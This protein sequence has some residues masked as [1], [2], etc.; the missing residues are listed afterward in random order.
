MVRYSQQRATVLPFCFFTL[1]FPILKANAACTQFTT[2]GS[3]S[4]YYDFY[5]FYDFRNLA[6]SSE[7]PSIPTAFNNG[8]KHLSVVSW[9]SDWHAVSWFRPSSKP[10]NYDMQYISSAMSIVQNTAEPH[11]VPT[12]LSLSAKRLANGTQFAAELDY[13]KHSVTYASMR[14]MARVRGASGAVA[15]F[16]TYYDDTTE[17]DVEIRTRDPSTQVQLSNQPTTDLSTT[18]PIPGATFTRPVEDYRA[19]NMYRLDWIHGRSAWYINGVQSASTEVNVPDTPSTIILNMWS[20]GGEFSGKMQPEDEASFEVQWIEL[21]Y[22]TTTIASAEQGGEIC[23]VEF[24]PGSP[25]S[26]AS[27]NV[28]RSARNEAPEKNCSWSMGA[29]LVLALLSVFLLT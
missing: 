13:T 8:Q 15:G 5:R 7:S 22:N 18:V 1:L 19:W 2:N 12:Y 4:A 9:S 27:V 25:V 21:L 20:N 29:M 17:S 14:V 28:Q 16:F 24:A 6:P 23:S 26:L 11:E 10:Q 3:T